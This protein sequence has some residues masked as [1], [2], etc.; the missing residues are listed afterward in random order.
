MVAA[1][2]LGQVEG[3]QADAIINMF[4]SKYGPETFVR[5]REAVLQ[6][7]QPGAQTE[8]MIEGPGG[9][10]DDQVMGTIGGQQKVATSPG[11]YIVPADVVS[12]LGD[13]S[14]E[15]GAA[16]LDA[17]MQRVRMA[18]GGTTTQPPAMNAGRVMPA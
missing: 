8:G 5:L 11:E 15:A 2:V 9:G 1:A 6:S 7:V 10:M 4:I 13:G 16:E 18:R 14:S 3:R 17:M 12:G